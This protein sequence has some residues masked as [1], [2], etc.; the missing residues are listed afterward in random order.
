MSDTSVSSVSVRPPQAGLESDKN[1]PVWGSILTYA[2]GFVVVLLMLNLL[3]AMMTSTFE[4]V[5]ERAAIDHKVRRDCSADLSPASRQRARG[6]GLSGFGG[7]RVGV[8]SDVTDGLP[9]PPRA[10]QKK[11]DSQR[12]HR[13]V[14]TGSFP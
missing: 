1:R 7:G 8:A 12:G 6:R 4:A 5:T 10:P 2:F 11:E 3:I 14:Q 13:T 9:S